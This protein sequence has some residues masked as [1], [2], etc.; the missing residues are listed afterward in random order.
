VRARRLA[1][2]VRSRLGWLAGESTSRMAPTLTRFALAGWT[3]RDVDT[4]V[5]DARAARGWHRIPSDLRRPA[6]YLALLLREV[7][8]ADRPG[9]QEEFMEEMERRER[10]YEKLRIWGPPCPHGQPAGN[11]PSPMRG[12]IACPFCR[13][14]PDEVVPMR[15]FDAC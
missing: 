5:R 15:P 7:D 12:T 13:G 8:P 9:A 6:A 10:E 4:A 2:A 1:E 3:P 14:V 11:V